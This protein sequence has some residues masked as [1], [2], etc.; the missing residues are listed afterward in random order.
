MAAAGGKASDGKSR[1]RFGP[2]DVSEDELPSWPCEHIKE[3]YLKACRTPRSPTT[4]LCVLVSTG[5]LCPVHRGHI[6]M[7]EHAR[8]ELEAKHN[9]C[10]LGAW[11]SPSQ[12]CYVGPKM[13]RLG[14]SFASA[15]H[16]VA[17]V[18]CASA[19]LGWLAVA[20]WEARQLRFADFPVV[21]KTAS[22]VLAERAHSWATAARTPSRSIEVIYVC[23]TDHATKCRLLGGFIPPRINLGLAVVARGGAKPVPTRPAHRV[24]G[25]TVL[26]SHLPHA[27]ST[28]VRA[29]FKKRS[30]TDLI[31]LI[32]PAVLEYCAR[33]KLFGCDAKTVASVIAKE[34][35]TNDESAG[36]ESG[37]AP[38]LKNT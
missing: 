15:A 33:H 16:R 19:D 18:K 9:K 5:A 17:A 32:G 31:E 25:I 10:V 11:L 8:R 36:G 30:Y 34:K 27:S 2:L 3:A 21:A 12:D 1:P 22:A 23:G 6:A 29:A 20:S 7:L 14:Q 4:S 28:K 38:S 13:L 24:Y 26:P 35:K 37:S